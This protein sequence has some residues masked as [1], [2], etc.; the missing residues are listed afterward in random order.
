MPAARAAIAATSSAGW[1]NGDATCTQR[2]EASS[3][4]GTSSAR[5]C[6]SAPSAVRTA[7]S[8]GRARPTLTPVGSEHH[9]DRAHV[10]PVERLEHRAAERVVA[11]AARHRHPQPEPR[12]ARGHDRARAAEHQRRLVDELLA[13][14]EGRHEVA[15]A[16]HEVRVDVPDDEEVEPAHASRGSAS[17][18]ASISSSQIVRIVSRSSEP[19][20]FGSSIAAW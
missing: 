17:P 6:A 1:R 18:C 19:D 11:H 16:Q 20:A 2:A 9:A 4:S 5:N 3:A 14:P 15:A 10:D 8:P 12:G 7:R 13:L